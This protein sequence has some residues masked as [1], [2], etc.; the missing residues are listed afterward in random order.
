ME[1][2]RHADPED[3]I[4]KEHEMPTHVR[5]AS[6]LVVCGFLCLGGC[7]TMKQVA[8]VP[9]KVVAGIVYLAVANTAF[10]FYLA[11]FASM[12]LPPHRV[13]AYTYLIPA[14]VVLVQ[15]SLGLGWPDAPVFLGIALTALAMLLLLRRRDVAA[16]HGNG[17]AGG[18][19]AGSGRS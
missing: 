18:A 7:Q 3:Q 11:K 8:Q 6:L 10:T 19:S 17:P 14:Y 1:R 16:P 12:Q 2:A 13:M 4:R 9:A 15:G 5:T